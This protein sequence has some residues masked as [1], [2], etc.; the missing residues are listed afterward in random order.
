MLAAAAAVPAQA[1]VVLAAI[2][3]VWLALLAQLAKLAQP[4]GPELAEP[5]LPVLPEFHSYPGSRLVDPPAAMTAMA[6]ATVVPTKHF[7]VLAK[8]Q[9]E[10]SMVHVGPVGPVGSVG[11]VGSVE[12]AELEVTVGS[13]WQLEPAFCTPLRCR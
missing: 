4:V 1:M 8:P 11:L 3:L 6:T 2:L 9:V 5:Q 12:Q 13:G 10:R 7:V